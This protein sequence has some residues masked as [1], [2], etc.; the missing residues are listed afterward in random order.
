MVIPNL[1]AIVWLSFEV[2][3]LLQDYNKKFA[4]GNV[5]YDYNEE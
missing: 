4:E 3:N 2:K 1:I 5:N